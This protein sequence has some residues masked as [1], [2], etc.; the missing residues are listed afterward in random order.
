MLML[1]M[2]LAIPC[3]AEFFIYAGGQYNS[4]D[5]DIDTPVSGQD[6]ITLACFIQVNSA[7]NLSDSGHDT[8]F[9]LGAGYRFMEHF[10]AEISWQDF[11]DFD[12]KDR[13]SSP[14]DLYSQSESSV[15]AASASLL[16]QATLFNSLHLFA[17]AGLDAWEAHNRISQ[18]IYT[19]SL[20]IARSSSDS[21]TGVDPYFGVG[22]RFSFSPQLSVQLEYQKH[23]LETEF[24]YDEYAEGTKL[25]IDISSTQLTLQ[26]Q[27]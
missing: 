7:P 2:A 1:A 22:V 27:I 11:G 14:I 5:V 21:D 8:G 17:R 24:S 16:A 26:Y 6:C 10:A 3:H 15:K 4:A 12:A 13:S 9:Q 23:Q 19:S 18:Q 25:D 20:V